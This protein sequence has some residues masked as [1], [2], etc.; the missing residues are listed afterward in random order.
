MKSQWPTTG[1][2]LLALA[3][4]CGCGTAPRSEVFATTNP[5]V[6]FYVVNTTA[7]ASVSIDF[8]KTTSYG[9]QTLTRSTP[10]G[11]GQA[12]IF[13]AGLQANSTYHMRATIRYADGTTVEDADHVFT[14]GSY[15]AGT[16]PPLTASPAVGHD[17]Q[18][19]VEIVNE[20]VAN[21]EIA[22]V[23]L[24]GNLLWAYLP[25][26]IGSAY[27]NAPKLLP[28]GDFIAIAADVSSVALTK[29]PPAT[30]ADLVRE[31]DL[32]GDTVKQIT[33]DQLNTE[34]AAYGPAEWTLDRHRQHHEERRPERANHPNRGPRRR[35]GGSRRESEAGLGLE[36]VR[37]SRRKPPPVEL[38]RLD[39]HK[40]RDLLAR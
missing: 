20:Q 32:A 29:T 28:D 33:M 19:G 5:Q 4:I 7:A 9:L 8:G 40:C 23:D 15:P 26:S 35:A 22:A 25:A 31:F 1:P 34:L 17:P 13:V 37:P 27:W 10:Q 24:Q 2:A 38:S 36:R 14:T 39:A 18:P 11:G 3:A 16:L 21:G 12:R 30:D 6:A